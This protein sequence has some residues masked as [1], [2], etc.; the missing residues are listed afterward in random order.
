VSQVARLTSLP[1]STAFRLLS[2]LSAA[3]YLIRQG[4]QYRLAWHVFELGSRAAQLDAG[5]REAILP[6]LVDLQARTGYT[7][8]LGVLQG[9][10]VLYVEKI[11]GRSGPKTPTRV[12][13]R[14]EATCTAIGKALLAHSSDEARERVLRS[15]LTRRT[16]FSVVEPGRLLRQMAQARTDGLAF[17]R[18]EST[19]GLTCVASPLLWEGEAWAAI[20]L[21]GPTSLAGSREARA[22]VPEVA[23]RISTSCGVHMGGVAGRGGVSV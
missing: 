1:K 8:H 4:S 15:R 12:G 21:S 11:P 14:V 20:S 6:R 18:E 19:V 7:V 2:S 13:A 9:S 22:L 23:R 5:L 16:P 17:D 3:G 10:D